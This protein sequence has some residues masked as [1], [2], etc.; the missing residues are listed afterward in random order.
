M[1]KIPRAVGTSECHG[2]VH[3]VAVVNRSIG[4]QGGDGRIGE[5]R[6]VDGGFVGVIAVGL[7]LLP[8]LGGVINIS[9]KITTSA[10][11]RADEDGIL[12]RREKRP[13]A[14]EVPCVRAR[15]HKQRL[16]RLAQLDGACSQ[17]QG[18]LTAIMFRQI[19]QSCDEDPAFSAGVPVDFCIVRNL[20]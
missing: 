10:T 9:L 20:L 12:R 15:S 14:L 19:E 13:D 6:A 18:R 4:C 11:V 1:R 16:A 2:R 3:H 8:V 5:R 7:E 17:V